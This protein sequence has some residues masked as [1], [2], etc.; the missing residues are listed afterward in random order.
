M[1]QQLGFGRELQSVS[2][3][4][5]SVLGQDGFEI[6]PLYQNHSGGYQ[7][8]DVLRVVYVDTFVGGTESRQRG[9]LIARMQHSN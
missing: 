4:G 6:M 7:V 8:A 3:W 2:N 1:N 9:I 5:V